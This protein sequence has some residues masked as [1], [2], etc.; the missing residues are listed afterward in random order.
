M[1]KNCIIKSG[2]RNI[3]EIKTKEEKMI[4]KWGIFRSCKYKKKK[5]K[6]FEPRNG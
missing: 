1:I 3:R 4:D 2:N 6:F 5:L